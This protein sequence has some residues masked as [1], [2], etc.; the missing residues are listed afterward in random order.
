MKGLHFQQYSP[1]SPER[2]TRV[3]IACFIGFVKFRNVDIPAHITEWLCQRE[4]LA[5]PGFKSNFYRESALQLRDVP[6]PIESWDEFA[7]LFA[8][9]E[10]N[11]SGDLYSATYLGAAVNAFFAQG[12]RKCYVIAC[13]EPFSY[14]QTHATRSIAINALLPGFPSVLNAN[15]NDR[16]TWHGL[17]HLLGLNDVAFVS[18][19]DLCDIYRND[20]TEIDVVN[21]SP[22]DAP[23]QFVE[24]SNETIT[25]LADTSLQG[26][27]APVLSQDHFRE[28]E[29]AVKRAV[30][31][32]ETHR[33]DVQLVLSYPLLENPIAQPVATTIESAF[34]QLNYPWV[35]TDYSAQLPQN[36]EPGEGS[37]IGLL[38]S[39][40]LQRGTYRSAVA[41]KQQY[42]YDTEPALSLVDMR[43][44]S[45]GNSSTLK[46]EDRISLWQR[47]YQGIKLRS[48]VTT[49]AST[50][51]R[52]ASINRTFSMLLKIVRAFGNDLLFESNGENLWRSVKAKFTTIL[53]SLYELG[54][55]DGKSEEDAFS[56]RC[57]RSIMTQ[58]DID[59]GRIIVEI[60][61][62]IAASIETIIVSMSTL[63][64]GDVQLT[65]L[66][67]REAAS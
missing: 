10:R 40:A 41:L 7:T 45:P 53:R 18:M 5:Y 43:A 46:L 52:S 19:P 51:Y 27:S 6:V 54:A 30:A 35:K 33:R 3:D 25:A 24:C 63:Q 8:W 49:S 31:F 22:S 21:N 65:S 37:I 39:N 61:V 23:E 15:K 17:G 64:N 12:G 66:G 4:W 32:I 67:V 50:V 26:I 56:V 38:A 59:N 36:L 11:I 55:I 20:L 16:N 9:Q 48:D 13:G 1:V 14:T 44:E 57:D 60:A 58:N 29:D 2:T 47:D 42:I 34:L 62:N 28:W